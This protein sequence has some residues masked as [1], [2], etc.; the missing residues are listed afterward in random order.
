MNSLY[1]SYSDEP[2][3]P[4]FSSIASF[5]KVNLNTRIQKKSG[6]KY[7]LVD[8]TSHQSVQIVIQYLDKFPIFGSRYLD[9][10]DW[11]E[12]AHYIFVGT[13]WDHVDRVDAIR[14]GMNKTRTFFN[15]DHLPY[16]YPSLLTLLSLLFIPLFIPYLVY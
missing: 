3:E 8:A 10:L 4:I 7:H 5:L 14:K 12:V 2:Y 16:I 1:D 6:R 11:K 9:Y 13:Q 15:W